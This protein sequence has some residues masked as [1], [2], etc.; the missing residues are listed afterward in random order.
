MSATSVSFPEK[1]LLLEVC[2]QIR[3]TNFRP[4][5]I[6]GISTGGLIPTRI[7]AHELD[8]KAVD[9]IA[10]K[11]YNADKTRANTTLMLEKDWSHIQNKAVLIVDDLVD[12]GCTME[13]VVNFIHRFNPKSIKTAVIYKKSHSSFVPDFFTRETPADQWIN[14]SWD[15][16]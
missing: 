3:Q 9:V 15:Q 13:F 10:V 7:I 2:Q 4:E 16:D 12:H 6:L 1:R 11:S 14:F 5:L 8:I